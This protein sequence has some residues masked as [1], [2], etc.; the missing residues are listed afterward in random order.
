MSNEKTSFGENGWITAWDKTLVDILSPM[1]RS[2]SKLQLLFFA[3]TF[4][5]AYHYAFALR[6]HNKK[7][8][9]FIRFGAWKQEDDV[10]IYYSN[11][12]I[13]APGREFVPITTFK[14]KWAFVPL[15]LGISRIW[16]GLAAPQGEA[17][18]GGA[19]AWSLMEC[20]HGA[21]RVGFNCVRIYAELQ[22]LGEYLK[23]L[24]ASSPFPDP[25]IYDAQGS[26][27]ASMLP[28]FDC[29]TPQSNVLRLFIY[30]G[31]L[32]S[33][34]RRKEARYVALSLPEERDANGMM[35]TYVAC[36]LAWAD[37]LEEYHT[38]LYEAAVDYPK[39]EAECP[40]FFTVYRGYNDVAW[41]LQHRSSF[42]NADEFARCL[43]DHHVPPGAM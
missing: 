26:N 23:R 4:P 42:N 37:V 25:I 18:R 10:E 22:D 15:T 12:R 8:K 27:G 40:P 3:N 5:L 9:D 11:V 32:S 24:M 33:Y 31:S 41:L 2:P 19:T 39:E 20:L 17:R 38:A 16:K 29:G 6:L 7:P 35:K 21:K 13:A 1:A 14:P 34:L 28:I 30:G 36:P 43:H